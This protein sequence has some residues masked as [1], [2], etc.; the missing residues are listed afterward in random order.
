MGITRRKRWLWFGGGGFLAAYVILYLVDAAFGGYDPYY[1]SD[2]RSRYG[3]GLLVHDCI[4]W[5]PRLGS[6]YNRYRHDFIGLA[7]YPLV[8]LDHD[9]MHRT[10][11]ISDDDFPKWWGTVTAANIHPLYRSAYLSW[12]TQSQKKP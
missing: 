10:H 1:S 12:R 7:F 8:Q 5:Q 2:G 4:I 6:Y 3:K 11:S 9:F